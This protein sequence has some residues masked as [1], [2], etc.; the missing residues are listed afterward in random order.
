MGRRVAF[1]PATGLIV[2]L[3]PLVG[4]LAQRVRE[5]LNMFIVLGLLLNGLNFLFVV[6]MLSLQSG[7]IDGLFP[8]FLIRGVGIPILF[9]VRP[10]P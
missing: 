7:Y 4:V 10:L 6:V 8:A 3:T 1:L 5:R 9:P 2:L